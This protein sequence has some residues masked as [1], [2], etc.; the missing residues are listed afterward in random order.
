[1]VHL[2]TYFAIALELEIMNTCFLHTAAKRIALCAVAVSVT[3]VGSE[4]ASAQLPADFPPLAVTTNTAPAVADGYMFLTDSYKATNYGYY[5][6]MVTNDGTPAWYKPL[7][8]AAF[9]FKVLPDGHLH[10]AQQ[11]HA[12]TW[13]GG[14]Y[15]THEI[16]DENFNDVESIR[17]GNGYNAE[18]HDF[19]MLPNGH[20][21]VMSYY[22]TQVDMSKIVPNGN[23]AALVTGGLIQELDAQRHVV[24]QWR[25]WDHFPI[26]SQW[27]NST[28][29]VIS[30][31]HINNVFEDTDGNIIFSS[32]S[33]PQCVMK[34][35]RQ[36]GKVMWTLG[37]PDN[38]F[39]FAGI[40]PQEGTNAFGSHGINRLPNGHVLFYQNSKFGPGATSTVQEYALDETNKIATYVWSF[41]PSPSVAGPSQGDAQRLANGNTFIGW[42]GTVGSG[43]PACTEISGTNVVFQMG[44]TNAQTTSYRAFRFPFPAASQANS[45]NVENLATGDSYTFSGTGVSIDVSGGG[46]GYNWMAVTNEPYA[47]IYPLFQGKAPRVLPVRVNLAEIGIAS[48]SA[49]VNFDAASLGLADPTNITV[50]YRATTGQGLFLPQPTVYNPV[51]GTLSVSMNLADNGGD[52]GEFIFGYPDLPDL[53]VPPLLDQVQNY[54][55]LQPDDV[56]APPLAGSNVTDSVNEDQPILLS[57][58]PAGIAAYYEFQIATNQD[59]AD[60]VLDVPGQTDAFFVWSN[61]TAGTI[62]QYRVRTYNDAGPSD[63]A[64]GSFQTVAP[65]LALTSPNGGELWRRGLKYFVQWQGNIGENVVIDL[66]KAGAFVATITNA[67]DTGAYQ[68]QV[69]LDLVP[70]NDYTIR[71]SSATNSAL[72]ADSVAP[73]SIDMPYIDPS[74]V[75]ALAGGQFSFNLVAPGATQV[76]IYGSTN[77]TDWQFLQSV[78]VTNSLASFTDTTATNGGNHF[79]QFHIP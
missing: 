32:F 75:K 6:M 29:A 38:D 55:G 70:G 40:T 74:S 36:T 30:A 41:T 63:W 25:S 15:V 49:A 71:I 11:Y 58:S 7:T 69:G 34:I 8:N 42:G 43:L 53:A 59:F 10:Y 3:A 51:T 31:F 78:F 68:W 22:M 79:F 44:F 47:P 28:A 62:Y 14:G 13:G 9:D 37:G 50:Y 48:M 17:A 66:Y 5:V 33:T 18:C 65:F 57:W 61:A 56:I 4:T 60:P 54:R 52:F 77:L 23:P 24:F 21:L 12:L 27:V 45:D 72:F 35:S 19:K 16:L 2:P 46:G 73:F 26:T 20:A 76:S 64:T 39:T 67:P 1:M